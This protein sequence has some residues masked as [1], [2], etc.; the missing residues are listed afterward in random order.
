MSERHA[1]DWQET[2]ALGVEAIVGAVGAAAQV[3]AL[4]GNDFGKYDPIFSAGDA[5]A[6]M[7]LSNDESDLRKANAATK[8]AMVNEIER[9]RDAMKAGSTDRSNRPTVIELQRRFKDVASVGTMDRQYN[10]RFRGASQEFWGLLNAQTSRSAEQKMAIIRDTARIS[11]QTDTRSALAEI[12]KLRDQFKALGSAGKDDVSLRNAFEDEARKLA[13]R[14]QAEKERKQK[15]WDARQAEKE[16]KQKEWQ[17]RQA[18]R[19][20]QQ[21]VYAAVKAERDRER[22]RKQAEYQARKALPSRSG[23]QA[24]SMF[25]PF[26]PRSGKQTKSWF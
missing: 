11:S 10:D 9:L 17:A 16:R 21:E 13:E 1:K 25:D 7:R 19:A 18:D 26:G 14:G 15:E 6:E 5:Y 3:D 12:R 22:A 8:A 20:R 24:R 2:A 4:L 23:K